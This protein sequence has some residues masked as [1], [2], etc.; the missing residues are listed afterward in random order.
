MSTKKSLLKRE[1]LDS[2][3]LLPLLTCHTMQVPQIW[4]MM[5]FSKNLLL[6]SLTANVLDSRTSARMSMEIGRALFL[7]L[8]VHLPYK[9]R[10]RQSIVSTLSRPQW[11]EFPKLLP[12]WRKVRP[13]WSRNRKVACHNYDKILLRWIRIRTIRVG[14][15]VLPIRQKLWPKGRTLWRREPALPRKCRLSSWKIAIRSTCTEAWARWAS[16]TS[17]RPTRQSFIRT[18]RMRRAKS[19]TK[20]RFLSSVPAPKPTC[21]KR[22]KIDKKKYLRKKVRQKKPTFRVKTTSCSVKDLKRWQ[23]SWN[24][25]TKKSKRT[26]K[27]TLKI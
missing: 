1:N 10:A 24:K 19:Q 16:T 5:R 18:N 25:L 21:N 20:M 6:S 13:K 15:G 17:K 8:P 26:P 22:Q 14:C 23:Q 11:L 9:G 4:K 2:S 3:K 27:S 7:A 12:Q